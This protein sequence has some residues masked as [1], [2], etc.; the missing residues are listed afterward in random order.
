MAEISFIRIKTTDL[1]F[2][3]V[4][5]QLM[6]TYD[7]EIESIPEFIHCQVDIKTL[8]NELKDKYKILFDLKHPE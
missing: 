6:E 3:K 1:K 2:V 8:K 4:P 7:Q 5:Y